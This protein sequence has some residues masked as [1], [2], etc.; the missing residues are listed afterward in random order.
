MNVIHNYPNSTLCVVSLFFPKEC[1]FQTLN[2]HRHA[3]GLFSN[4]ALYTKPL[5][6]T[7]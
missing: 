3:I 1:N 5:H 7:V 4:N 6:I 2:F